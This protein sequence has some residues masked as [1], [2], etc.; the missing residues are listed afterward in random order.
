M[1]FGE[2][3]LPK[4]LSGQKTVTRRRD[5]GGPCRYAVGKSYAVQ[6]G[7]GQTAVARLTVTDVSY[8]PV[9]WI[10]ETDAAR[11]GFTTA[12]EF[13]A[14]WQKLYGHYDPDVFVW[15]IAFEVTPASGRVDA[16]VASVSPAPLPPQNNPTGAV[17]PSPTTPLEGSR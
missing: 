16:G 10:D 11:E 15:R 4:V 5:K 1:I 8:E 6:P 7:R 14:Y 3:L 2:D 12:A 9:G 13:I 17:Y